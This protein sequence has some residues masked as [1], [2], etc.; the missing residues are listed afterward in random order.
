MTKLRGPLTYDAALARIA[1]LVGWS[2]M[3]TATDRADRTV[4]NWGD[5]DAS[6]SC[7]I[8]CAELLDLAFQAAGG[9]GAPMFETYARRL[10]VARAERFADERQLSICTSTV[11]REAGEA[12][13]ALI[14]ASMPGGS[15]R[16]R[17]HALRE[18]EQLLNAASSTLPLLTPQSPIANQGKS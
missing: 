6:E 16:D 11:A 14:T 12:V 4:R 3:A 7:P 13:A 17:T 18:V 15:E 5:P 2:A 1:G 9:E 8:E 10:D